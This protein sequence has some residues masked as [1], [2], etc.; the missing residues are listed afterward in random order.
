MSIPQIEKAIIEIMAETK[1]IKKETEAMIKA[2]E[3]KHLKNLAEIDVIKKETEAIKKETEAIKKETEALKKE[4]EANNKKLSDTL[5]KLSIQVDK[6]SSTLDGVGFNIGKTAEE[7]FANSIEKTMEVDNVKYYKMLKNYLIIS[8]NGDVL[9]EI[10]IVLFNQKY[11]CIIEVKHRATLDDLIKFTEKTIPNFINKEN[12]F[13]KFKILTFIAAMSFD[14][15]VLEAA[16]DKK[17]GLL[18]YRG[19]HF[20]LVETK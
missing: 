20:K 8:E 2:G 13:K 11:I 3:A 12:R 6:T 18:K 14:K 7:L 19:E 10:D 1:V 5:A 16:K 9:S 15:K 4:N 17:I